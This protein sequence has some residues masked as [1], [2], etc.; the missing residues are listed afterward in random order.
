MPVTN[1]YIHTKDENSLA[2]FP[3]VYR[4]L[5][6]KY[7]ENF[8]PIGGPETDEKTVETS[9]STLVVAAVD[10]R[11]DGKGGLFLK[12]CQVLDTT[13]TP[14]VTDPTG[15]ERLWKLSEELVGEKFDI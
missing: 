2:S 7:G 14:W 4:M 10:D 3:E 9:A 15:A 5:G 1:L 12:N 6:E 13:A 8:P 11:F